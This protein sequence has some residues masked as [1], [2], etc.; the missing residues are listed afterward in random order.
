M[1]HE[2][3]RFN[4]KVVQTDRQEI[5]IDIQILENLINN[6]LLQQSTINYHHLGNDLHKTGIL[7]EMA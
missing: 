6:A 7:E 1:S 3:R 2:G 5:T 4:Q